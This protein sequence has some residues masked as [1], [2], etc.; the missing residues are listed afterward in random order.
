MR[1]ASADSIAVPVE[2]SW[3]LAG[4]QAV[5]LLVRFDRRARKQY[6]RKA[7]SL[8]DSTAADALTKNRPR[9]P[10]SAG[11]RSIDST[12]GPVFYGP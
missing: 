5:A 8:M 2:E 11:V 9:F 3:D 7:T 1:A 4:N 10:V 6:S 12:V